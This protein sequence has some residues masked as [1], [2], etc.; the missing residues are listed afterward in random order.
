MQGDRGFCELPPDMGPCEAYSQQYFYNSTS[1]TCEEFVYGGCDGN[2]NRF[3]S[4]KE[5]EKKCADRGEL[6]I[7]VEV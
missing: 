6:V 4:L 3:S 2:K 7:F 1:K 5:C